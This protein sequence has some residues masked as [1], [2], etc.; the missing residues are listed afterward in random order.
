MIR[1]IYASPAN[2]ARNCQRTPALHA[3][4]MPIPPLAPI[5]ANVTT[6]PRRTGG[7]APPPVIA[8]AAVAGTA[9]RFATFAATV[10]AVRG[11]GL[12]ATAGRALAGNPTCDDLRLRQVPAPGCRVPT[13]QG[14]PTIAHVGLPVST[15]GSSS[16]PRC[17]QRCAG[18]C[19]QL[20][21]GRLIRS[22]ARRIA[23]PTATRA[24]SSVGGE[25]P[26]APRRGRRRRPARRAAS[27]VRTGP[28]PP[29]RSHRRTRTPRSSS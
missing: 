19:R 12:C 1:L 23:L 3:G 9:S 18:G 11:G 17:V 29:G 2:C 16:A 27:P 6:Q 22:S 7:P 26:R 8:R 5:T 4:C 25:G 20:T 15:V 21:R 10:P 13:P 28:D 14:K 24:R